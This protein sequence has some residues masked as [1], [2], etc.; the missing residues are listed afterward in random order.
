M[1]CNKS[2]IIALIR[3]WESRK[4]AMLAQRRKLVPSAGYY[5]MRIALMTHIK[6]NAVH[7]SI[8]YPVQCNRQLNRPQI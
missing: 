8:I 1:A 7:R 6:N 5:L 4:S 2:V 3:L